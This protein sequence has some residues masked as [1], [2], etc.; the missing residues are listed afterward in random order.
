[1]TGRGRAASGLRG[2]GGGGEHRGPEDKLAAWGSR[3]YRDTDGR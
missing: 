1:M 3:N 2:G